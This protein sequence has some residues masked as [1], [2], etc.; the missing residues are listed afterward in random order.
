MDEQ[1][2]EQISAYLDGELSGPQKQ[3]V[4]QWLERDPEAQQI[5]QD[6][7]RLNQ[8]FARLV[9]PTSDSEL[10]DRVLQQISLSRRWFGGGVAAAAAVA[11][12]VLGFWPQ[13][14]LEP[15]Q[16]AQLP[17]VVDDAQTDGLS[18]EQP[19]LEVART[20]ILQDEAG[21]NPYQILLATEAP[22]PTF[23]EYDRLTS[24]IKP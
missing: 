13:S 8:E 7:S 10:A 4:E 6:L 22:A 2:F 19:Y 3:Q 5:Y 18:R 12:A 21:V 14:L 11:L 16:Q 20:Y 15:V 24:P 17:P 23:D 1:R 9:P